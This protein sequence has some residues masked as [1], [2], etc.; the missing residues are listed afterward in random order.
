VWLRSV[1]D[2]A[3][4]RLE[5]ADE[6]PGIEVQHRAR[7]FERFYRVDPGRSRNMGGTGL[8]LAIVK[9]LAEAMGGDV[10]VD[11][12]EPHGAVFWL[13]L[14]RAVGTPDATAHSPT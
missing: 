1:V 2:G 8:G 5:V 10:G 6:G 7:V 4:V 14:P 13:R 3:S 12:R 11:P 9:H